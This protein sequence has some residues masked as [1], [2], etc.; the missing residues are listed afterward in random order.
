MECATFQVGGG[1]MENLYLEIVVVTT[2][3]LY[4][5]FGEIKHVLQG[6]RNY[7]IEY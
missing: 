6:D 7:I 5:G 1:G 3:F 4:T 2:V